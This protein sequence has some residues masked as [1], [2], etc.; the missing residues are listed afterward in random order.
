[1]PLKIFPKENCP[2]C[3]I[4]NNKS[5]FILGEGN[6]KAEIMFIG[7]AP[8]KEEDN[9]GR[10]FVGA[11]GKFLDELITSIGLNRQDVFI[12]NIVKCRPP[13]N[14]DPLPQETE[15]YKPFLE[16]QI[17]EINPKIIATLGRHAM[18]LLLPNLL[19]IT[20]NHGKVFK[21]NNR[22]F[23]ILYH[24]AAALYQNNLKKV[25]EEDFRKLKKI[26]KLIKS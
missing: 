23:L 22:Y 20:Q 3:K 7:E 17:A 12:T 13:A 11:A 2:I 19:S 4:T 10:P 6:P 9:L 26:I 25:L 14:R 21:K 24:P 5:H 8:G 16:E 18:Q 1:M 15:I